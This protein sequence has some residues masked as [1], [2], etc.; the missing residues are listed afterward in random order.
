M[1]YVFVSHDLKRKILEISS[2]IRVINNYYFK[3]LKTQEKIKPLLLK[4]FKDGLDSIKERQD[5]L[6]SVPNVLSTLSDDLLSKN[7]SFRF[8]D[9]ILLF[10]SWMNLGLDALYPQF[11][12]HFKFP[13]YLKKEKTRHIFQFIFSTS[14]GFGFPIYFAPEFY[15][16]NTRYLK[17]LEPI[18]EWCYGVCHMANQATFLVDNR[19]NLKRHHPG[20]F[21]SVI[22]S[23]FENHMYKSIDTLFHGY[24][25]N[26]PKK[27]GNYKNFNDAL[28][29]L[30]FVYSIGD[31]AISLNKNPNNYKKA[32][33][34]LSNKEIKET[35]D[36]NFYSYVEK[37][38][39]VEH[40][41]IQK[42]AYY[43]KERKKLI[44]EMSLSKRIM[45]YFSQSKRLTKSNKNLSKQ[46]SEIDKYSHYER[47]LEK[48]IQLFWTTPLYSHTI[49]DP[50]IINV[51][52]FQKLTGLELTVE[53]FNKE[54]ADS[55]I[56]NY[57]H[58][59]T[60]TFGFKFEDK[61]VIDQRLE[62]QVEKLK[63]KNNGK[64][65]RINSNYLNLRII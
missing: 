11:V 15:G 53:T 49:H 2:L 16:Y 63:E 28:K 59:Y 29:N 18:F 48:I 56:M 6:F 14:R 7:D 51:E 8:P 50:N 9:S 65:S 25:T 43:K 39:Q 31:H 54:S 1:S 42:I 62:K 27:L 3:K 37:L 30:L 34:F 23:E 32:I 10:E 57:I 22:L 44:R 41:L 35:Y 26:E 61:E 58:Q 17:Y 38:L 64:N 5:W 52:E 19:L 60:R 12:L 4:K 45:F 36:V 33:N 47:I 55:I 24:F 20:E 40:L 21:E 13:G 46:F